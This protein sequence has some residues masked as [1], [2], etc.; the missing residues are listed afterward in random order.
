MRTI[1][2]AVAILPFA[3]RLPRD[4]IGPGQFGLWQRRFFDFLADQVGRSC[5]AVEG[6]WVIRLPVK[7][8]IGIVYAKPG[9]P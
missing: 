6:A 1:V 2:R 3:D 7:D 8:Q 9:W 5:L 4:V